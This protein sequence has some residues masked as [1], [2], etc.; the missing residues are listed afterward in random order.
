MKKL[1]IILATCLL[2]AACGDSN[3]KPG[4][5]PNYD[6]Q[7][8][9]TTEESSYRKTGANERYYQGKHSS[10]FH[11]FGTFRAS[12]AALDGTARGIQR[13]YDVLAQEYPGEVAKLNKIDHYAVVFYKPSP[14]CTSAPAFTVT[15]IQMD[16]NDPYA[17]SE[18]D[19]DPRLGRVTI[20]AAGKMSVHTWLQDKP[21]DVPYSTMD[22]IDLVEDPA[23]SEAAARHEA[24]HHGLNEVDKVRGAATL[25]HGGDW[26]QILAKVDGRQSLAGGKAEVVRIRGIVDD[27]EQEFSV[28]L[29]K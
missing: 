2:I 3:L 26:E 8:P 20:C 29:V 9:K 1:S 18:Y 17:Q 27:E 5:D 28:I 14:L 12:Q 15:Y 19:L 6:A 22:R 13:T 21:D 25:Y 7:A 4:Y 24:L 23:M 11:Y 16:P 10:G